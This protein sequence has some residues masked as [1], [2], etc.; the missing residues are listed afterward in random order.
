MPDPLDPMQERAIADAVVTRAAQQLREQLKRVAAAIDPFPAFPGAVFAYGIEVEPIGT[1][2]GCV[3]LGDDGAF[4]ELQIGVDAAQAAID[5]DQVGT[6]YEELVPL[7][8]PPAEFVTYA[9]RA[10]VSATAYLEN[11]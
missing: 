6:R 11:R 10:I 2:Q 8:V 4:Y 7:E 1:D 9:H 3:I 5:S